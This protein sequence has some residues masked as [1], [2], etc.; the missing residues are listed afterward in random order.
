VFEASDGAE[1][2]R[3]TRAALAW[4]LNRR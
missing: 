4:G 3:Q 2:V 1:T